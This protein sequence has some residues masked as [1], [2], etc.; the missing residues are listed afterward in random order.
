MFYGF[1]GETKRTEIEKE[2]KRYQP[3]QGGTYGGQL[4]FTADGKYYLLSRVFGKTAKGDSFRLQ[5]ADTLLDS[6]DYTEQAG[7]EL[8]GIDAESFL[9]TIYIGQAECAAFAATDSVSAKLGNQMEE[10]ED[11]VSYDVANKSL[12]MRSTS[13]QISGAPENLRSS[14]G[15]HMCFRRRYRQKWRCRKNLTR[16]QTS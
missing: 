2:R 7:Q 16:F 9:R 3:W 5:D 15:K 11:M 6:T 12:S 8:F 13:Y 1:A 4:T 14:N 10:T